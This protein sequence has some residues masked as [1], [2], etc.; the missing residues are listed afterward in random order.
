MVQGIMG[1]VNDFA[2]GHLGKKELAL[3]VEKLI[4]ERDLANLAASVSEIQAKERIMV[5][6][7][8][9]GD[10]FTK[11]ARPSIIYTGLVAAVIDGIAAI[12][13]TMPPDFWYVWG[14]VCGV[15]VLG[16]TAEK[17]G[18]GG[19]VV[20]LLTGRKKLGSILQG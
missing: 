14:G 1:K 11:R 9:Q 17:K 7:L 5:A 3:T 8:Q 19:K 20:D 18:V 6:E 13:F 12:D 16:R 15:Y 10:P 2:A 4:H